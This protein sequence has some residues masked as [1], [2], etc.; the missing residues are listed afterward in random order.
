MKS[1][2]VI[3]LLSAPIFCHFLGAVDFVSHPDAESRFALRR[4]T[5]YIS[6][7]FRVAKRSAEV[8]ILSDPRAIPGEPFVERTPEKRIRI[9]INPADDWKQDRNFCRKLIFHLLKSKTGCPAVNFDALPDWFVFGIAGAAQER[10]GSARLARNSH[11]FELLNVLILN[12]AFGDPSMVLPLEM[13]KLTPEEQPFFLE[14]AK[15]VVHT[16]ESAGKFTHFSAILTESREIVK[17]DFDRV[18]LECLKNYQSEYIAPQFRKELWGDLNPPPEDFSLRCLETA[19]KIPVPELDKDGLPT[20]KIGEISLDLL[21]DLS[22]RQDYYLLC[23]HAA[24]GLFNISVGES[25]EVR[26]LLAQLRAM[27]EQDA[28]DFAAAGAS[29]KTPGRGGDPRAKAKREQKKRAGREISSF[30]EL[31]KEQGKKEFT[32]LTRKF[33]KDKVISGNASR[34]G[35]SDVF[36]N[37]NGIIPQRTKA[38]PEKIRHLLEVIRQTL[39]ERKALRR[40]LDGTAAKERSVREAIRTRARFLENGDDRVSRWLEQIESR[41]L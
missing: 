36:G 21:P 2:F 13:A 24:K 38:E 34:G 32:E 15:L 5:G 3:F 27:F 9:T 33:Y 1:L 12:G 40:Q 4:L 10:T 18:A 14:Y 25:R 28:V 39:D 30:D 41:M 7:N 11:S 29:A 22:E 16:L 19:C 23:R 17:E 37:I 31:M 6:G 35:N 8:D 26:N 20:G